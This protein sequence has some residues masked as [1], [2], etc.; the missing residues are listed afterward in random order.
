MISPFRFCVSIT[1]HLPRSIP[2]ACLASVRRPL[3]KIFW[4][5]S[6]LGNSSYKVLIASNKVSC[7]N[8]DV[9]QRKDL[10]L[11]LNVRLKVH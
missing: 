2:K 9:D 11:T 6:T 4:T 10:L 7:P 1:I 5:Y 8:S 3:A